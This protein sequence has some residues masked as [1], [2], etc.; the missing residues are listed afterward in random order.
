MSGLPNDAQFEATRSLG[1]SPKKAWQKPLLIPIVAG[2]AEFNTG[3][4]GDGSGGGSIH[5]S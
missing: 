5:K 4:K 3:S 1:D 2:A